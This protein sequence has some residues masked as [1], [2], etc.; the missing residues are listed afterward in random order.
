MGFPDVSRLKQRELLAM[1]LDEG[2]EAA[3]QS[4]AV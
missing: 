4:R 3:E 2:G 1:L